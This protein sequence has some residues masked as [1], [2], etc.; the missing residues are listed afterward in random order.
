MLK[1]EKSD[2]GAWD[3]WKVIEQK[4]VAEPYV[5]ETRQ[6]AIRL[7]EEYFLGLYPTAERVCGRVK[8]WRLSPPSD[9]QLK[10]AQKLNKGKVEIIRTAGQASAIIAA[11]YAR[12]IKPTLTKTEGDHHTE[13]TSPDFEYDVILPRELFVDETNSSP[14]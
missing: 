11:H 4:Y 3:V 2:K 7:A 13:R 5:H 12:R 8:Q 10:L 9:V 6:E 14:K 1:K